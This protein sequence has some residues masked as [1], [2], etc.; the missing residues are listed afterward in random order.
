MGDIR[1]GVI[2]GFVATTVLAILFYGQ[3]AMHYWP[4][5]SFIEMLMRADGTP[6]SATMAWVLHYIIGTAAWGGLFAVFSPHLPGP[7]WVRGIMFGLLAWLVMMVAFLPAAGMAVFAGGDTN[8][9]GV[10][11][12]YHVIFGVVLGETYDLLLRYT[13]SEVGEDA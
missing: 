5:V 1:E 7:H 9:I 13:P 8:I 2:A 3:L 10:T 12:A 6:G 11:L 4:T